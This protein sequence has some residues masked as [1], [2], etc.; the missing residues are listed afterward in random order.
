MISAATM[1]EPFITRLTLIFESFAAWMYGGL[2]MGGLELTA[3][4]ARK[5]T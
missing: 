2:Q 4:I 3:R 5:A 1:L